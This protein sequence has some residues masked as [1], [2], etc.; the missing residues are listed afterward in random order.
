MQSGRQWEK[1]QNKFIF[2]EHA[3]LVFAIPVLI[4]Q[5]YLIASKYYNSNLFS[6]KN[7]TR[8]EGLGFVSLESSVAEG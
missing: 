3:L 8:K 7:R 1:E 5:V 6:V 2:V 4:A